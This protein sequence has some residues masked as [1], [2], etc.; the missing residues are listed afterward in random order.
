MPKRSANVRHLTIA[1]ATAAGA[2]AVTAAAAAAS[3]GGPL[4]V[5]LEPVTSG[6][7]VPIFLTEPDDG[8]D[9]L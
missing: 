8:S 9:R 2:L 4:R 6:L 5:H 1:L 3:A 7:T